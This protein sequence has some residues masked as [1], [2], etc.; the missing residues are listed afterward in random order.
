MNDVEHTHIHKYMDGERK[1]THSHTLGEH[2]DSKDIAKRHLHV[3]GAHSHP[4]GH[5][6]F[7]KAL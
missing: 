3:N 7:D 6:G 1:Y 5:K 4:H 2:L